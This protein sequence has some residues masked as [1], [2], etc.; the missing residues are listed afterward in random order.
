[1]DGFKLI[2]GTANPEFAKKVAE[3]LGKDLAEV[4]VNRFSDGEI[5][6]NIAES[7]RGQDMFIIQPTCAPANDNYS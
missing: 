6:V 5:N 1:M 7:V 3:Y 2:S 4:T